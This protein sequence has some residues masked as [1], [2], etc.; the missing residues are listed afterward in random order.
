MS[1]LPHTPTL[2]S[3]WVLRTVIPA[4]A[5]C[6]F[7][8]SAF[9][10][11]VRKIFPPDAVINVTLPPYGAEPNDNE[12]D[13]AAIQ[14]AITDNVDTGRMLYFPAGTYLISD[15]LVSK[16]ADGLWRAHITS[17][18]E[19]RDSTIFKLKDKCPG[20]GDPK[21]PRAMVATGS[22]WQEGDGLDGGGNKAFRNNIFDITFDSGSG[23][24]GAIGIDYA[25]SNQGAIKNV[26]IRSGDGAGR[27]GIAL[28]RRIPG[29]GLI[30]D[31]LITGFETGIDIGDIQY[32]LTLE[33]IHLRDQKTAG[34]RVG[35]NLLHI[36]NLQSDNK[37]PALVV[38][39][40]NGTIT[41]L[42]SRL[43]GGRG[44]A[45]ECAGNFFARNLTVAGYDAIQLRDR[46]IAAPLPP[47]IADPASLGGSASLSLA[48]EETPQYWNSNL[49]DWQAIGPR[50]D[51]EADDTAAIQRAF[52]SGKSTIYFPTNRTYFLSDTIK[53]RGKVRHVLG[54]GSE[55]S[56]GAASKPFSDIANPRPLFRIE[57][58]AEPELIFENLFFNAQYPGEILF[59]NHSN[60]VVAIKHSCGWVGGSG[61]RRTYRNTGSGKL[62]VEDVFLPGWEFNRQQ[63]W[64][65]QFNP[66]NH[67]GD[68]SEPQVRNSGGKLWILGFKTEGPAPFITTEKGGST[69][70]LG[71]YNYVSATALDPVPAASVPYIITD[72]EASLGFVSDNFRDND[73]STYIRQSSQRATSEWKPSDL[74][75][76]SGHPGNRSYAVPLF[77]TPPANLP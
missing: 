23:N 10:S 47:E 58:D 53:I 40:R 74:P 42:D 29:P 22:H 49:A 28:L 59:E 36:R 76:R 66:E 57:K 20:F 70:L 60:G 33:N 72:S 51:G 13:T 27:A 25:V 26:T 7:S 68:G 32:G 61:H 15:T 62:F 30:K 69:E 52:D 71:A 12:D 56:L 41:L 77:R 48:I 67:D 14:R 9:A 37:V 18:G 3:K 34:I 24:P 35:Q 50:L 46:K 4:F 43:A 64:A 31:V 6:G 65:R 17:Q 2:H 55:I 38:T 16:N 8:L 21:S 75:P 44:N 19:S 54:M 39:D 63:V 5:F 1:L 11:E 45:I 73:Y